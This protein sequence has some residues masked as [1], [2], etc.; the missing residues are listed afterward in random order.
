MANKFSLKHHMIY[1]TALGVTFGAFI[2]KRADCA[3]AN[4]TLGDIEALT[5][6]MRRQS[7]KSFIENP[8]GTQKMFTHVPSNFLDYIIMDVFPKNLEAHKSFNAKAIAE[9]FSVNYDPLEDTEV[10]K[11]RNYLAIINKN[12][13][14]TDAKKAEENPT[15]ITK[16]QK[17]LGL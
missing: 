12:K 9:S 6:L 5:T 15:F 8:D 2:Q 13:A 4:R 3:E 17:I 7:T 11:Q 14:L 1:I 16:I 10:V